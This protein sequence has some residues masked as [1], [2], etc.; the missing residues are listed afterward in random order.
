LVTLFPIFMMKT[1]RRADLT[2]A[3]CDRSLFD[4]NEIGL[5]EMAIP[6]CA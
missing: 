3:L 4:P 2:V 5:N 6:R 1:L